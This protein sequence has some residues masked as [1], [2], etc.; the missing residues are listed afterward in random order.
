[1]M[2]RILTLFFV[3]SMAAPACH[4]QIS[5]VKPLRP[6]EGEH[7][8]LT[9][10]LKNDVIKAS[11][12]T[13]THNGHGYVDLGLPSGTLWSTAYVGARKPAEK[14]AYFCWGETEPF[15]FKGEIDDIRYKTKY[16]VSRNKYSKYVVHERFG[17]VDRR[18]ELVPSDDP[19]YVHWGSGWR[20]PST[21]QLLEL[22]DKCRWIEAEVDGQ[23]GV[24]VIGPNGNTLF[25]C[26]MSIE[27]DRY[28]STS[29]LSSRS[30]HPTEDDHVSALGFVAT[31]YSTSLGVT[32]GF[33]YLP[34]AVRPV[35]EK[36]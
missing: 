6:R 13:G 12:P 9:S 36:K 30:L 17:K 29:S 18:K 27:W 10:P 2:R 24:L 4:A 34:R 32:Y 33:R 3:L 23:M 8:K 28:H 25:F 1:M 26:D 21:R 14:G 7:I 35:L 15:K 16:Y 19:A 20:S 31:P 11:S 5:N 22:Y